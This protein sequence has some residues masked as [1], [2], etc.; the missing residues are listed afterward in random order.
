MFRDNLSVLEC[1][2]ASGGYEIY[3][4]IRRRQITE[5]ERE[6]ERINSTPRMV[7]LINVNI[8]H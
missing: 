4:S 8:S 7:K 2:S 3:C 5:Q 1:L 6:N